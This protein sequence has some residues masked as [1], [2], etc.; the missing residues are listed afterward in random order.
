MKNNTPRSFTLMMKSR[1]KNNHKYNIYNRLDDMKDFYNGIAVLDRPITI[2]D[3][4][5]YGLL[6]HTDREPNGDNL[7]G[8]IAY[9]VGVEQFLKNGGTISSD[10]DLWI[11]PDESA[12]YHCR[13]GLQK[14]VSHLM[15]GLVGF[16]RLDVGAGIEYK[17][18]EVDIEDTGLV[19]SPTLIERYTEHTNQNNTTEDTK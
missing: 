13:N 5:I 11:L 9:L 4:K 19:V 8:Y 17:E 6:F 2:D 10:G 1:R 7:S 18:G 14:L 12:S 16:R 15:R 3:E